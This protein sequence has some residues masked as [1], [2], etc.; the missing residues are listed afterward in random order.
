MAWN[1]VRSTH[2][3]DRYNWPRAERPTEACWRLWQA[4]L[5]N[6]LIHNVVNDLR[7]AE[8]LGDWT[9]DI[10]RWDW[11]F[12]CSSKT[13]FRRLPRGNWEILRPSSTRTR[14]QSRTFQSSLLSCPTSALPPDCCRASVQSH[15]PTSG[16]SVVLLSTGSQ[17]P[18]VV[19]THGPQSI[20]ELWREVHSHI[21]AHRGWVPDE[22]RVVGN[23]DDLVFALFAGTLRIIGDGSYK[24]GLGTAAVQLTTFKGTST[25]WLR[26]RTPGLRRDQSAYR[27]ELA[28]LYSGLMACSWLYEKGLQMGLSTPTGAEIACNGLSALRNLFSDKPLHSTQRQFDLLSAI[29]EQR[30]LL[31]IKWLKRHVDGHADRK[32]QVADLTW[33]EWRNIECDNEAQ[34]FRIHIEATTDAAAPNPRFVTEPSALFI[35]GVKQSRLDRSAIME[36]VTLPLLKEYWMSRDRISSHQFEL[37]DWEAVHRCM[38]S[39]PFGLQKWTAKH[40]VGMCGVGKFRQRWGLDSTN[41]CPRCGLPEDHLHVPRREAPGVAETWDREMQALRSW[42][43]SAYTDPAIVDAILAILGEIR[44]PLPSQQPSFLHAPSF[45]SQAIC[46]QQLIGAQSLLEGLLAKEWQTQQQWF[47]TA[48]NRRNSASLWA[49]RLSQQLIL[50]G[51]HLWEHRNGIQHSAANVQLKAQSEAVDAQIRE[52]YEIGLVDLP[53]APRRLLQPPIAEVLALPLAERSNWVTLLVGACRRRRRTLHSQRKMIYDLTHG[54][55]PQN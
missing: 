1:G 42:M 29:R 10:A 40:T 19:T 45:L 11:R 20:S 37:I 26:C 49:S 50:V 13:L 9:D 12:S 3:Q 7:L 44:Q 48:N 24:Q 5:S 32:K 35:H 47:F 36:L 41:Q 4:T 55:R 31:P 18:P 28:S 2:Q 34:R 51:F 21:S 54:R 33:W 17:L 22:L 30:R 46:D 6:L 27:S 38:N 8:P 14:V 52:Q 23:E 53:S 39:L 16:E 15:S 43:I 25:I